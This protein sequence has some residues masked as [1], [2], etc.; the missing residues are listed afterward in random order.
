MK[1]EPDLPVWSLEANGIFSVKSFYKQINFGGVVS[2]IG[3]KLWKVLCPQKI[4]VF[5][6]LGMYNK[7]LTRDN[8]AKRR[9]VDDLTCPFCSENE[10]VHHLFFECIVAKQVWAFVADCFDHPSISSFDD[11]S[12]LWHMCKRKPVLNLIVAASL[13]SLWKLRNEFCFQGRTWRNANCILAK[14]RSHLQQWKVLCDDTQAALLL[15]CILL[16]DKRCGELMRI[17]WS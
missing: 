11:V 6:W 17:A 10:T 13:W 9:H 3:G 16:L 1:D 4:H 7:L 15:K 14:L 12:A 2:Q 8:L 5:L